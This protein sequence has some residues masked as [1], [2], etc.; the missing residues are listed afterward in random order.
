MK[1]GVTDDFIWY[2]GSFGYQTY[3]L[4]ALAPLF[5]QASLLGRASDLKR[6]MLIAQ[7][8][9]LAPLPLRFDNGMLPNPGDSTGRLKAIDIGFQLEMYRTMPTWI[10]LIEAS[11]KKNW[12][13]LLDPVDIDLKVAATMP[14]VK[15]V[16]LDSIRMAVLKADEWQV[17]LRY[18]Q[19]TIHHSQEDALSTED[20]FPGFTDQ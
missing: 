18:G 19:R 2:E 12:D 5:V 16:N 14:V 11:R 17:F 7:N 13:T 3:V 15:S 4:R 8:M 6:E 1:V 9:L 10:S 20:L